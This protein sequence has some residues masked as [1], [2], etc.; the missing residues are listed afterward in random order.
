V[1]AGAA[2]NA[3]FVFVVARRSEMR[4]LRN[5]LDSYHDNASWFWR[6]Y[7]PHAD[8]T[9]GLLAQETA[10]RL[11]LR[12]LELEF[13]QNL[14]DR[15]RDLENANEIVVCVADAWS[16]RLPQY[17]RPLNAYDEANLV[18]CAVL[19]TGRVSVARRT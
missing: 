2:N 16:V 11:K 14:V 17:A 10:S 6:P 8:V 3:H 1:T 19:V 12:Y 7:Y 4:A 15:L 9:V 18:N 5:Y 13:D